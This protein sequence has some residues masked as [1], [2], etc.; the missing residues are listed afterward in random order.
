M[1]IK[2]I[3]LIFFVSGCYCFTT[4]AP[5]FASAESQ[6]SVFIQLDSRAYS[7]PTSIHSF[8]HDFNGS[9]DK[10][11]HAF[12]K[13]Q[14]EIGASYTNFSIS[15]I[16]RYD[17]FYKF[18]EE[19]AR[20]Y[21]QIENDRP[22]TN[23]ERYMLQIKANSIRASGIKLAYN[24]EI[25]DAIYITPA[26]SYLTADEFFDNQ[27]NGWAVLQDA[28]L[29]SGE[30]SI[31]NI[32]EKDMILE[33]PV[34]STEGRGYAVDIGIHWAINPQWQLDIQLLDA[35]SAIKWRDAL[36]SQLNLTTAIRTLDAQGNL[37]VAPALSGRQVL[38]NYTQRLPKKLMTKI[39]YT[40]NN[41]HSIFT[42][43]YHTD[44]FTHS[45]LGYE[46][47]LTQRQSIALSWNIDTEAAG[48]N[49]QH[50][51]M[52]L[53]IFADSLDYKKAHAISITM[54]LNIPF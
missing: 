22:Q 40:L 36:D 17:Q 34:S 32:A 6:S 46:F 54:G 29:F 5:A 50:D 43:T 38:R 15:Y 47:M 53:G 30:A 52:R 41:Q 14:L 16:A 11:D 18:N 2:R 12:T 42:E 44:Y 20:L 9:F 26:L 48:I 31:H 25:S 21:Y 7:Q 28:D 8:I 39:S 1:L 27:T 19:T 4:S 45:Q 24:W 51:Y 23:G 35:V 33:H 10:G 3:L 13:N 49:Y 37:S